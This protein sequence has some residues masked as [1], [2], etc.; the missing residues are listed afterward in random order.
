MVAGN[1]EEQSSRLQEQPERPPDRPPGPPPPPPL[2]IPDREVPQPAPDAYFQSEA[3]TLMDVLHEFEVSGFG[4]QFDE[5]DGCIRCLTCRRVTA[6]D[7]IAVHALRR[8]E[9]ASDPADAL[10]VAAVV[11]PHCATP[12]VLTL[13]YGPEATPGEAA[14]LLALP[15]IDGTHA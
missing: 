5:R 6:P 13:N 2:P 14:V 4:A 11:C 15:D 9:G 3:T 8:L 7:Q 1:R 10:A 12:G